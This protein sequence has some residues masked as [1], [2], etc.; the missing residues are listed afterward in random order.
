MLFIFEFVIPAI[1]AYTVGHSVFK[2]IKDDYIDYRFIVQR[3]AWDCGW[4]IGLLIESID[5]GIFYI[6]Y[7]GQLNGITEGWLALTLLLII[8]TIR[9]LVTMRMLIKAQRAYRK[10]HSVPSKLE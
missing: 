2:F 6:P 5:I 3:D 8:G 10:E 9:K 1:I 7:V 4:L